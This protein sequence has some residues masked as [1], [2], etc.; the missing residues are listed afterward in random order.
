MATATTER[1]AD[2]RS[3]YIVGRWR[4]YQGEGRSNL[5]RIV[6]IAAFYS[7]ELANY[8]G[9]RLGFFEMPRLESVDRP[10]HQAVTALAVAWTMTAL[11]VQMCLRR[12]VFPASLKF[13]STGADIVLLTCVLCVSNGPRS[14]LV[15]GYFLIVALAA[16]RFSLPL[17]RFATVGSMLGYLAVAG[18]REV[19]CRSRPPGAALPRGDVPAG[20]GAD[21]DHD[22]P[23]AASGAVD[24]RRLR[25]SPPGCNWEEILMGLA[26]GIW[27][28]CPECGASNRPKGTFCFLCGH[29]LDTAR[30]ETSIGA[31]RSPISFTSP[32]PIDPYQPPTTFVPTPLSFR[33][34]SLLMVIAVIAVCLGVWHEEP[35]LGIILAVVV[36]PA[37][38]YTVIV[39]AKSKAR[40][41]RMA[42]FEKVGTF[43]AAIV[44]AVVIA[45]SAI[46]AFFVTCFPVGI[47]TLG[48]AGTATW[49]IALVSGGTAAVAAAAYMT[50]RLL[51]RKGRRGGSPRK[52]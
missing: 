38:V 30:P 9:L 13:L 12:Q 26:D 52:P 42:V 43:L 34:S 25:R 15:V 48:A 39:A 21:R 41:R 44:G 45:V 37:L 10:F 3:W 16:L 29:G 2:D 19:V 49:I 11:A 32:E 14:P 8:R 17:V 1:D 47:V 51:T 4:E 50:Y 46:I 6:G 23:G 40:G 33:I 28:V 5:L 18:P 36:A 7:V 22:R 35:V 27:L 20:S 31:P 24:G